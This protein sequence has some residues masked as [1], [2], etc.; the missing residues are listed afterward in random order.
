MDGHERDVREDQLSSR[1]RTP[2]PMSQFLHSPRRIGLV[3]KSLEPTIVKE[4]FGVSE[5]QSNGFDPHSASQIN[6]DHPR[7]CIEH[8][9]DLAIVAG[10]CPR[11]PYAVCG[12][13]H[14]SLR[15]AWAAV[16]PGSSDQSWPARHR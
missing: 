4:A 3:A 5:R 8:K 1:A 7:V 13:L 16:L 15:R 10:R 6:G 2:T 12:V 9:R 14:G 11:L